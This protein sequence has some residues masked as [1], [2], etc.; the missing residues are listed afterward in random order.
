MSAENIRFRSGFAMTRTEFDA[1][2]ERAAQ[3][4][5]ERIRARLMKDLAETHVSEAVY[6]GRVE[7][8]IDLYA[9][10]PEYF[11]EIVKREI[12]KGQYFRPDI[13]G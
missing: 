5:K 4:A 12:N 1:D 10:A 9:A 6:E 11:W 3:L 7:W 8:T 2:P 13:G